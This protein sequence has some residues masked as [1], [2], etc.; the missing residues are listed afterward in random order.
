MASI[1]SKYILDGSTHVELKYTLPQKWSPGMNIGV[2]VI[3]AG[4]EGS[5]TPIPVST[6]LILDHLDILT[7]VRNMSDQE[8]SPTHSTPHP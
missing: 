3:L 4:I 5:S 7:P 8:F 2:E 1:I 6:L